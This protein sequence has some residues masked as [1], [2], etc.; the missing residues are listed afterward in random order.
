MGMFD[1]IIYETPCLK[2][3]KTIK[4]FQSKSGER[5]LGRLTPMQ[6]YNIAKTQWRIGRIY[7][8]NERITSE[9]TFYGACN[10]CGTWN[11]HTFKSRWLMRPKIVPLYQHYS[12]DSHNQKSNAKRKKTGKA[13]NGSS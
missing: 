13:P 5:V 3:G 1:D 2:C 9:P 10:S 7:G 6:L 8:F 11:E 12:D 4:S